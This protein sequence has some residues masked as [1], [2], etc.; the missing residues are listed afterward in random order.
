M[1]A[2]TKEGLLPQKHPILGFLK[3]FCHSHLFAQKP[4]FLQSSLKLHQSTSG[5]RKMSSDS[6]GAHST[7]LWPSLPLFCT[8]VSW[9]KCL[10]FTAVVENHQCPS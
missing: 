4:D 3:K 5:V 1:K 9:T 7:A 2:G 6:E 8:E 10:H